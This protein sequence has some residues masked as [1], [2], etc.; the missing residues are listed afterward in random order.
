MHRQQLT[1]IFYLP[2]ILLLW[3]GFWLRIDAL[4][5]LP[6]GLSGDEALNVVDGYYLSESGR[7]PFYESYGEMEP[8]YR[9]LLVVGTT[10]FGRE[11]W[12]FRLVSVWLGFITLAL[13][14]RAMVECTVDLPL[15]YRHVVGLVALGTL[16]VALGH[17]TLSRALYRAIVQ[18][19]MMFLFIAFLVRGVRRGKTLDFVLSA[20]GL[21]GTVHSY[22][23]GLVI[24]AAIFPFGAS[25]IVFRWREW[26][27]WF[28]R[29]LLFGL[30]FALLVSP[31]IYFLLTDS[32]RLLS[33][34][35]D[36]Q[37][38]QSPL[39]DRLGRLY[40]Q[41]VVAGDINPQYNVDSAPLV[42]YGFVSIFWVGI[43]ALILRG[44]QPS[45]WLIAAVL[46]LSTIPVVAANEVPH[47]LRAIGSFGAVPLVIGLGVASMVAAIDTFKVVQR[48]RLFM[49]RLG[50]GGIL[51]VMVWSIPYA[52]ERYVRSWDENTWFI[53]EKDRS[54]GDWFFRHDKKELV[55]WIVAQDRPVLLPYEEVSQQQTRAWLLA[56]YP[57]VE[58]VGAITLPAETL[59]VI[60]YS[61]ERFGFMTDVTHFVLLEGDTIKI[62]PPF[63]PETRDVLVRDIESATVLWRAN[64]DGLLAAQPI[65]ADVQPWYLPPI[66]PVPPALRFND[67]I[68]IA[69]WRGLATLD[70]TQTEF[71]YVLEWEAKSLPTHHY[72]V[73]LG[74]IGEDYQG[75]NGVNDE[76][77]RWVYPPT[78][79]EQGDRA[80]SVHRFAL[81]EP[82]PI[83]PY[84]VVVGTRPSGFPDRFFPVYDSHGQPVRDYVLGDEVQIGW[85]KVA[86]P[87]PPPPP[88]A[89]IPIDAVFADQITLNAATLTRLDDDQIRLDLWWEAQVEYPTVDATLFVH[90]QR[91]DSTLAAQADSRPLD[92]RYP[93]FIWSRGEMVQTSYTFTITDT[94]L[95]ALGV[96]V[97]AY[98]LP[99]VMRLS[100]IQNG[101]PIPDQ[102]IY[103]GQA[104]ELLDNLPQN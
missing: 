20:I 85:V 29:S 64:G 101:E 52:H 31:V 38:N 44:R 59:V 49:H 102:R 104:H 103:L 8:T 3:G 51:A 50:I 79:W 4:S 99:D 18:P 88:T 33:R 41:F 91:A 86:P 10:L 60:P 63:L 1:F 19:M 70:P 54:Y 39:Q 34:V 68:A 25:L 32:T 22:T 40:G 96:Y 26:R 48:H 36:V 61:L 73:R 69:A 87:P 15:P 94:P 6:P 62:L 12:A 24:P 80:Y 72:D 78:I 2:I 55:A 45:S 16:A 21:A 98:T 81:S 100:V 35:E 27:R 58:T 95:E 5:S 13:A 7:Y 17:V 93:T 67:Q 97:G 47:G 42:P 77:W 66:T 14:Y 65:A 28:G 76:S 57:A 43:L 90:L 23:S 53:F 71:T 74:L 84:R 89:A 56:Q 83:G 9:Y 92:G 75:Y 11:V 37:E 82:L 30:I 46:V